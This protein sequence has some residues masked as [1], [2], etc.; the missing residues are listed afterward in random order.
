ML[1][2]AVGKVLTRGAGHILSGDKKM[3]E[4]EKTIIIHMTR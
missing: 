2:M 3:V 4:I 1:K